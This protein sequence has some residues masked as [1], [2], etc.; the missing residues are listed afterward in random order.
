MSESHIP[1]V[2]L[3]AIKRDLRPV[4]PLAS[5]ARR[6]LALLPLGIALLVGLPMFW[7]WRSHL[8]GL[9]SW[10]SWG[11]SPLETAAGLLTL[12]AGFREAVPGR[13]LSGKT[14]SALI[15]FV[16]IVF[17]LINVTH[18]PPVPAV[19][20]VETTLRWI[21]EC[22]G[23]AIAFSAPALALPTWLVSRA[24]PNRPALTGALCGLG[25]GLMADAGLR[26]FC[27]D[28]TIAHVVI[29]H[30][31]AIAIVAALGALS[32]TVME[33]YR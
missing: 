15:G 29:A 6:A 13:E 25:V 7:S 33:R 24:L 12:A 32:A 11:L 22:I 20:P 26:L 10:A 28:G 1:A 21:W 3:S 30:G 5:P 9:T 23:M 8:S 19:A 27:W 16:W 4:R 18:Q 2:L 31:G 14:L 17:L